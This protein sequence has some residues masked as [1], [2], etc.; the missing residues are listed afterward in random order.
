MYKLATACFRQAGDEPHAKI[1]TAYRLMAQAKRRRLL[2]DTPNT[3]AD[4]ISAA[5]MMED[6]ATIPGIGNTNN[7][8]NHAATCYQSAQELRRAA[9]AFLKA[10]RPAHG[11]QIL[12]DARDIKHGTQL[13]LANHGLFG[14]TDFELLRK[15][16]GLY[17]FE[18]EDYA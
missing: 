10:G 16:A 15:K 5:S 2:D 3:R 7:L 17:F 8:Y 11:I 4:M 1:S 12:F 18:H 13:L 9:S 14:S 6:C